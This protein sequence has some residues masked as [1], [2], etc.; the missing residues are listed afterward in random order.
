MRFAFQSNGI[1]TPETF[2]DHVRQTVDAGLS[3]DAAIRAL[4]ID[5]ADIA[6]VG[7]RLGSIEVG[8]I[9]NLVVTRGDLF[10]EDTT[11]ERVFVD[12]RPVSLDRSAEE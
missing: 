2:L 7:N 6:G 9:A 4:T 5:A 11:I 12:G 10:A 8:K 1:E 3:P